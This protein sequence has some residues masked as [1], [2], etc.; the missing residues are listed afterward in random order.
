[1]LSG[2]E[3]NLL[4]PPC[5][6]GNACTYGSSCWFSHPDRLGSTENDG[7]SDLQKPLC[8]YG[9]ACSFKD[10]CWFDHSNNDFKNGDFSPQNS[11]QVCKF[12]EACRFKD[13]CRFY[14]QPSNF[15]QASNLFM[16][17]NQYYMMNNSSQQSFQESQ[18]LR[19]GNSTVHSSGQ[20]NVVT[21]KDPNDTF[22]SRED[23]QPK[24]SQLEQKLFGNKQVSSAINFQN[25]DNIPVV[26]TGS[27][28]PAEIDNFIDSAL[29]DLL[30]E[31]IKLSGYSHPTPVQKRAIP[32][33]TSGR[34]LMACA[35]TGSGKTAA[36]LLPILSQNF[37]DGQPTE[38]ASIGYGDEKKP[39][40]PLTLI[41]TPTRELAIQIFDEAC[42]FSYRSW[43]RPCVCYGGQPIFDQIRDLEQGCNL[44]VATPGRLIDLIDRRKVSLQSVRY[45]VMDEAD[46]M[47]NMGFEPQIRRI[48]EGEDMPKERQ[49]LMFSATF[50]KNIKLLAEDFLKEYVFLTV[51]RVGS[52]SDTIVQKIEYVE[53]ME[54]RGALLDLL[55]KDQMLNMQDQNGP[56]LTLV[57]V[58]KRKNCDIVCDFLLKNRFPATSIH[59]NRSQQDR[60]D[61]LS[62]FRLGRIPILVATSVAA[63]GLDIPY[64]NHVINFD[65]PSDIDEYVHRIGR[66]ANVDCEF[67]GRAGN[68]GKA[69]AFFNL[70]RDK[71]LL[72]DLTE[73]L[74]E[75]KQELPP[76][77]HEKTMEFD[78]EQK[79]KVL[80]K[81][82]GKLAGNQNPNQQ[83]SRG[84]ENMNNN[85]MN[86]STGGMN[87]GNRGGMIMNRGGYPPQFGHHNQYMH[88]IAPQHQFMG[89]FNPNPMNRPPM[90]PQQMQHMQHQI[91]APQMNGPSGFPRRMGTEQNQPSNGASVN[92]SVSPITGPSISGD[93]NGGYNQ[94]YN[95]QQ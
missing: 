4:K 57:F 9:D 26:V 29:D 75:A 61:A 11:S 6:L 20:R 85:Y 81:K 13:S 41:L 71:F 12:G 55:Q 46:R 14:H 30:K 63:R 3:Q 31:T 44:L 15:N 23:V 10:K 22:F 40:V 49:T 34:D 5:K 70:S 77:I 56:N 82:Q 33:V 53:E 16:N 73:L 18:G 1:M 47:L 51:G 48:V 91:G 79:Q 36:F 95:N 78:F 86:N 38:T 67:L 58:E 84:L 27:N 50:P 19:Q 93:F 54:K 42:K 60:E 2:M 32:I 80:L 65:L 66:T 37:K 89:N 87:M 25:Y 59:G 28:I 68:N 62:M 35:Q 83:I 76:W 64:V 52:T 90:Y 92:S 72:K 88:Q 94:Y 21:E 74:K 69:T 24:N 45:F 8:K 43:V 7:S 39:Q 17:N